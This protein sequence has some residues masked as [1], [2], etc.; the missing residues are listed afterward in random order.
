MTS[1]P[2]RTLDLDR[3]D[4]TGQVIIVTGAGSGLGRGAALHLAETGAT[5]V[6]LSLLPDELGELKRTAAAAG[7]PV[8]IRQADVGEAEQVHQAIA[9]ILDDF[10]QVDVLI[11]NAGI[12]V[13]KPVEEMTVAEWDRVMATNLR[14]VFLFARELVPGMKR[15]AAGLMIN[16]SSQSGIMG[17][18]GESGYCPSK[19]GVEGLTK[20]LALEL[21]PWRIPVISVTPGAYMRTAMSLITLGPAEQAQWHE[22]SVLA[23]AFSVLVSQRQDLQSGGRYDIWRLASSG[24]VA[25]GLA[26][27]TRAE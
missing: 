6:A 26:Q 8:H 9:E 19:H 12:I 20:T 16:V 7:H 25:S 11:N 22:P 18:V 21:E 4:L 17:F 2:D 14:S 27:P 15:R 1:P 10:G 13:L 3:P 23:P 5:V 24:S